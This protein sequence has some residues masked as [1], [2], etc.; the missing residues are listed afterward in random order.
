MEETRRW[1]WLG[2]FGGHLI[3]G[4]GFTWGKERDGAPCVCV[5]GSVYHIYMKDCKLELFFWLSCVCSLVPYPMLKVNLKKDLIL[6]F[7]RMQNTVF[8]KLFP[9]MKGAEYLVPA[10]VVWVYTISA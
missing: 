10:G 1:L 3:C 6:S 8:Q 9:L 2:E 5:L 4:N 7:R